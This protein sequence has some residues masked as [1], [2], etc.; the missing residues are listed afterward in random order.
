MSTI[1]DNLILTSR[2]DILYDKLNNNSAT[3]GKTRLHINVPK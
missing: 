2:D 3:I 1:I